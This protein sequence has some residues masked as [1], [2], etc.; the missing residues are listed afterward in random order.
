MFLLG[1]ITRHVPLGAHLTLL[2]ATVALGAILTQHNNKSARWNGRV[3][4][5]ALALQLVITLVSHGYLVGL[6][7]TT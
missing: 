5:G 3:L 6:N 4:L 1:A 7:L 2:A